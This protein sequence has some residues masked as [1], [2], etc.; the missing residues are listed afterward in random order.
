MM[1]AALRAVR[2]RSFTCRLRLCIRPCRRQP[3]YLKA[4]VQQWVDDG[5]RP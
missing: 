1:P 3:E 5:A 2:I 4:V